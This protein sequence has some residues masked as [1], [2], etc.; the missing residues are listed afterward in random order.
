MTDFLSNSSTFTGVLEL[1]FSSA[2]K[3][4]VDII[5]ENLSYTLLFRCKYKQII[6]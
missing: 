3:R 5:I 4:I 2:L 1:A 6:K